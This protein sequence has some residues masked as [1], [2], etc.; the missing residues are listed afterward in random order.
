MASEIRTLKDGDTEIHP[1]TVAKAVHTSSGTTI[2]VDI[3]NAKAEADAKLGDVNT[4]L[5]NILSGSTLDEVNAKIDQIN[6]ETTGNS[7]TEK[8]DIMATTK[9]D[10]KEALAE[11]GKTV[12]DTFREFPLAIRAMETDA[13]VQQIIINNNSSCDVR[14][15]DQFVVRAGL[16]GYTSNGGSFG[17]IFSRFNIYNMTGGRIEG[18]YFNYVG[19]G[20]EMTIDVY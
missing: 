13:I 7:T 11:K 1:R 5:E 18:V 17:N 16:Q 9:S 14:F 4:V 10:L 8:L 19:D 12:G 15:F 6:G 20:R 2:D 3:A